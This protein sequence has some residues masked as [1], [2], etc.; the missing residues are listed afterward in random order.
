MKLSNKITIFFG[1]IF[2]ITTLLFVA[3]GK[4]LRDHTSIL[5]ND[6]KVKIILIAFLVLNLLITIIMMKGTKKIIRNKIKSLDKQISSINCNSDMKG[7]IQETEDNDEFARL[8]RDIN[9]MFQ[10]IEDQNNLIISNEKKYSNLV[11]GLD[12]GYAYFKILRDEN[13]DVKDAFIVEVNA[14]L[15]KMIGVEK[16]SLLAG[17]F[18][19]IIGPFIKDEELGKKILRKVGAKYQSVFRT[20][21]RL[22]VDRWSYLTVYPIET[23]YFAVI[24]T[25][26]S[27]NKRFAEEMKHLANY[28]VLTG[29]RNRFCIYNYLEELKKKNE[30]F[31]IY[32]IDLDHFKTIND[33]LGHNV[34]DE[35]LVRTADTISKMGGEE[36]I[37]GRLGGDEFLGI[38]EGSYSIMQLRDFGEEILKNLN[39]VKSYN[40]YPYKIG[41]SLGASRFIDDT[42]DIETLLKYGDIALYKSKKAGRNKVMVFDSE[43]KEESLV[44]NEVKS[45]I[46]E[47]KILTYYQPI[48]DVE[49]ENSHEAEALI[50]WKKGE[51]I[52]DPMKFIL[53]AKESDDIID[54]DTMV[55]NKACEFC[56]KRRDSGDI[57]F[58][59]S[60]NTSMKFL[61]QS[62]LLATIKRVLMENDLEPG[63]IRFDIAEEE[64][65]K[66]INVMKP[67]LQELHKLGV[68]IALDGFGM[69]YSSFNYIKELP[70]DSIKID[71]SLLNKVE[72]DKKT[73]AIIEALVKLAHNLNIE[74]VVEG[75]ERKEQYDYLKELSCDKIQ[76]YYISKAVP[77]EEYV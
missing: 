46:E 10:S 22:G 32:Y 73:L 57:H 34:G 19:K 6:N 15:V 39:A 4:Y 52:V 1:T 60:I 66:D 50:R 41:A 51:E 23:E 11:E 47:G 7:R 42:D 55:F 58:E 8:A 76:G 28:D 62:D 44:Q 26:I 72:K 53:I 2:A 77:E 30:K 45:A 63:A 61:L 35:V 27:E 29:I 20:S 5:A 24:F 54:I 3:G 59:V 37:V 17:S 49:I 74:V 67:V 69:G 38:R 70:L 16:D 13:G 18:N 43:M 12:N 68:K 40:D 75:V 71:R 65:V 25:D 21:I 33:T 48:Y 56:K 31:A 36:F 9:N 14:S 64:V